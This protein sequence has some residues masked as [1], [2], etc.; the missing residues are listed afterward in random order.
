MTKK[1]PFSFVIA[2]VITIVIVIAGLVWAI[3]NLFTPI[4]FAQGTANFGSETVRARVVNI[5]VEGQVVLN[6][7]SQLY[8][9]LRRPELSRR[10][11]SRLPKQPWGPFSS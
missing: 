7:R 4:H 8:Q 1:I 6:G 9:V 11:K 5:A 10:R 2:G 3:N